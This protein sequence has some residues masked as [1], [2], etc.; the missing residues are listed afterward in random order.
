MSQLFASYSFFLRAF[1]PP[2]P[3]KSRWRCVVRGFLGESWS[4]LGK[5]EVERAGSKTYR[6]SLFLFSFILECPPSRFF[7]GDVWVV[8]KMCEQTCFVLGKFR[9]R[10]VAL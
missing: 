10:C 5:P 3:K 7:S 6:G 1:K 9:F 2:N 4:F 8:L